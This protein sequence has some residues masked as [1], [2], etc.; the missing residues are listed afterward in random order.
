MRWSLYAV[1]YLIGVLTLGLL[2]MG[3]EQMVAAALDIVFLVIAVVLFRLALKDVSAA[4]DISTEDRERAELRMVQALLIV[5]FV[6]SAS[7]LGYSFLKA[8]FPFVP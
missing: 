7:V 5:T 8:V 4:L 2:L 1:L 6:I 3:A